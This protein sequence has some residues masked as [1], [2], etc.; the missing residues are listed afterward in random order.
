MTKNK[1]GVSRSRE[2]II[3]G[4]E[5]ME[6]LKVGRPGG[7]IYVNTGIIKCCAWSIRRREKETSNPKTFTR[8]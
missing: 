1:V 5:K 6:K 7:I 2:D 8:L 4:D 3:S